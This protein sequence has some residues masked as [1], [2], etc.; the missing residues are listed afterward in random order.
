MSRFGGPILYLILFGFV[1]MW[2]LTAHDSGTLRFSYCF[3]RKKAVA[4]TSSYEMTP[5]IGEDVKAEVKTALTSSD[6]LRVQRISKAF[7]ENQVV[8]DLTFSMGK[9]VMFAML[10]PNGCGKT[11]TINMIR[12]FLLCIQLFL[13]LI[14]FVRW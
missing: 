14:P 5:S 7:G 13:L 1:F 11:T 3:R 2:I 6:I 4:G 9:N 12:E 10:G 8:D